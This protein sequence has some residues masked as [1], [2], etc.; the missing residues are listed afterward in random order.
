[1]RAFDSFVKKL[2][3]MPSLLFL[4]LPFVLLFPTKF[5]IFALVKKGHGFLALLIFIGDKLIGTAMVA[6]LFFLT[7]PR[8]MS[9]LW[10]RIIYDMTMHYLDWA[11]QLLKSSWTY[12]RVQKTISQ[13][14][15]YLLVIRSKLGKGHQSSFLM[16][17]LKQRKQKLK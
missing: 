7:R 3:P 2:R 1:M 5:F 8:V 4:V 14:H 10:F 6:K 16:R 11:K 12:L 9:I 17:R 13:L 15:S